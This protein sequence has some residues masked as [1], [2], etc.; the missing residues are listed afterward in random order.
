[1][2]KKSHL[3]YNDE[4]NLI[5][6][7]KIIWNDRIKIFLITIGSFLIGF[8][9]SYQVPNNYL[10]SLDVTHNKNLEINEIYFINQMLLNNQ[11]NPL[12]KT[13][14][15][16]TAE[17]V[18]DKFNKEL[19]DYEEF[20]LNFKKTKKFKKDISKLPLSVQKKELMK[21]V[22]S[23]KIVGKSDLKLI[24]KWENIDE[25]KDILQNTM[26]FALNNLEKSIFE[27]INVILKHQ[28]QIDR[29]NSMPKLDYLKKQRWIAKELNIVN[30]PYGYTGEPYYLRGYKVIDKEIKI[31]E[32]WDN[33]KFKTIQQNINLLK[34]QSIN[35]VNYNINSTKVK[36]LKNTKLI[37][38]I[39][40]FL[41]LIVGVFYVLIFNSFKPQ[42][43]SKKRHK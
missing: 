15:F 18:L 39:P 8:G 7:F 21:Y 6:L 42:T 32:E 37:L 28:E 24:L 26:N 23:L 10:I 31:L 19:Q 27:E 34:K 30:L 3:Y 13:V 38:I 25:A 41:G 12:E 33:K 14:I 16:Y 36:S 35:W 22:D 5:E 43:T 17:K 4:I 9:Y 20:L 2:K 29:V 1:M 11:K 40:I